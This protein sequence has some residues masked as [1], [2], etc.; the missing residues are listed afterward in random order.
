MT[1]DVR[2]TRPGSVRDRARMFIAFHRDP[3]RRKRAEP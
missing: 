2:G 1:D 3:A